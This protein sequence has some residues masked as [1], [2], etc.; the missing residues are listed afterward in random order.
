MTSPAAPD[1][2]PAAALAPDL[3]RPLQPLQVERRLAE[4]SR[5]LDREARARRRKLRPKPIPAR[6]DVAHRLLA[7][8]TEASGSAGG[9]ECADSHRLDVRD[10]FEPRRA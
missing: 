10:R 8:D 9:R 6:H 7:R 5:V 4:R 3:E 2:P 1:A